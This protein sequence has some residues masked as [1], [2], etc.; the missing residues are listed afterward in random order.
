[1]NKED[2][3]AVINK[4]IFYPDRYGEMEKNESIKYRLIEEEA[5][6]IKTED[7]IFY[8]MVLRKD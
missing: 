1:M 8:N 4:D 6:Y 3:K 2:I 7:M 5:E